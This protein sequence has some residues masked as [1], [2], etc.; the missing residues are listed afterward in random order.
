MAL[1]NAPPV[2]A[3]LV[4]YLWPLFIVVLAPVWL[5][6]V[7]LKPMHVVAAVLG[8]AGA[9]VAILGG[10]HTVSAEAGAGSAAWGYLA[11]GGAAFVWS[12][13]S[14]LTQRAER[15][16]HQVPTAAVGLFGAVSGV[17][18]LLCHWAFEP[19]AVLVM[20]DALLLVMLGLGPLGAAFFLWDRAMKQGDARQIGIL[21]YVHALAKHHLA[22]A[23]QRPADERQH[24]PVSRAHPQCS[25]DGN[26]GAAGLN[27][28]FIQSHPA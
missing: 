22:V 15:L 5:T 24:R 3:N 18:A 1:Q 2:E 8:F 19:A 25:R 11:A 26:T 14:L 21:S 17:L 16:G 10:S 20:S 9:A 23:H 4:N 13:Y 12:S 27:K 28:R 6:G 7:R